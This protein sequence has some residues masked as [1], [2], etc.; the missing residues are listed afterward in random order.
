M[1]ITKIKIRNLFGIKE[2]ELD[3]RSVEIT[4]TNGTGKTS[5]IDSIRYALTNSSGR[6]YILHK[7]ENEGEII[8]E[9]DTGVY[10]NRKKRSEQS[11]YKSVKECGNEV[12]S[13][14]SFLRQLFTPL[15]LDPVAFT[16]MTKKE[17]NRAILDLI[18][19][20][21][22]LNWIKEQF[23]EIPQDIDY[24]QNILQVLSD[25]QS[26][27]GYYFKKRQDINRDIR[28]QKAFIA[29]IAK[30]LPEDFN[31]KEWENYDLAAAYQKINQAKE[32]NNRI[33]RAKEFKASYDGKIRG[34]QG[35][36]E[37]E[38]AAEKLTIAS[39]RESLLKSIERMKAEISAAQDKID[40]LDG[41]LSDKIALA[42]S[43][44]NE[45]VSKLG[46]DI[47]VADEYANKTPV[48]TIEMEKQAAFAEEMKKFINEYNRMKVMQADVA[49]LTDI[50]NII[51][52]KIE[53]AR[54]L[55][56]KILENASLPIKGLTVEKGIPLINGLPVSNLS[57]GEQ[58]ELCIDVA[59]SKPNSLQI[60]L[61]DGAE[62]L[63][64]ENR[65]RLYGK[66]REKGVQFI[67]ARTTDNSEM[68]VMYL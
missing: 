32:H 9:T 43:R 11:D 13:P 35:E 48:D 47:K 49:K 63:S 46:A 45:Q 25:I 40:S 16:Q 66:C 52:G 20:P 61:I 62:K 1:K 33:E 18:D 26:E 3:S 31:A 7:G 64:A 41:T 51:T 15:Q 28:N 56:G 22:D 59:L 44:Y 2:T 23:G 57:E 8:V 30:D 10:I 58:L 50:S 68:E 6:D 24:S 27:N 29:D 37:S 55:P 36:M 17:Q 67:A 60:I 53:L 12:S 38:I 34:L 54:S 42:E 65:E 5:V 4:G 39:T 14:E 19:F 21:W